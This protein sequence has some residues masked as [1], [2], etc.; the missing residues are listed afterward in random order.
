MELK[1]CENNVIVHKK[2]L[3]KS[4]IKD[5]KETYPQYGFKYKK[6]VLKI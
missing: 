3:I 1:K 6:N 4:I 5:F 2:S